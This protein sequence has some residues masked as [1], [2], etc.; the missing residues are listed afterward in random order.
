MAQDMRKVI[1]VLNNLIAL[2]YDAVN[3]YEAAITR[4]QALEIREALSEFQ[5]DHERH[6][7]DLSEAVEMLGGVARSRPDVKG[8]FIQAFT[9][10]GSMMGDRAALMA[11]RSDEGMTNSTY[12]R[13]LEEILWSPSLCAMIERNR[14]DERRHHGFVIQALAA[15]SE[16]LRVD[17]PQ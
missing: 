17:M 3:A 9:A 15:M 10:L 6:I 13:A 14:D 8:Y 1:E 2:D 7:H 16:E 12:D 5:A 11:I 4:V